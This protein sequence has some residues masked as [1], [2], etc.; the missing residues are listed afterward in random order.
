LSLS[1]FSSFACLEHSTDI[2]YP[3]PLTK[4]LIQIC[5]NRYYRFCPRNPCSQTQ[6]PEFQTFA[7]ETGQ[8]YSEQHTPKW[9]DSPLRWGSA[10]LHILSWWRAQ[11]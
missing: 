6:W 7:A 8:A 2:L 4:F 10:S 5:L 11:G 3:D 1:T 9:P